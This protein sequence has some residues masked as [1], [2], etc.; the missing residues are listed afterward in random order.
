MQ[1][2]LSNLR[3]LASVISSLPQS[4]TSLDVGHN[5][6]ND[7]DDP[8]HLQSVTFALRSQS[9]QELGLA[10]VLR[11]EGSRSAVLV[12][13]EYGVLGSSLT[14]LDLRDGAISSQRLTEEVFD[15]LREG[16]CRSLQQLVL[17]ENDI[18]DHGVHCFTRLLRQGFWA[19][20]TTL[21]LHRTGM[22]DEGLTELAVSTSGEDVQDGLA[23]PVHVDN[24]AGCSR[25]TSLNI[26]YNVSG[27][28]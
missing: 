20:L 27:T 25:L 18:K 10:R 28:L 7:D 8:L 12:M 26:G 22:S 6:F 19:Q 1:N 5:P 4:L 14:C 23:D 16:N 15:A 3:P 9:L 24:S 2:K 11:R 17:R 21:D 13:L